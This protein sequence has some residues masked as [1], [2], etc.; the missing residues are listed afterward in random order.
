[1]ADVDAA[2]E[3]DVL[4]LTQRKRVADVEHHRET[5]HLRRAIKIAERV[6]HPQTLRGDGRSLKPFWSD[7][8]LETHHIKR[9]PV[10]RDGWI[11]G[12]VSVNRA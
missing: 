6:S 11:V 3:Q 8:V 1:M 9:V 2:L 4:D 7:T 12:I 10:V 5:D